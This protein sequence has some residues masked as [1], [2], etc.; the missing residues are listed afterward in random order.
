MKIITFVLV[1]G[2]AASSYG[3]DVL[4]QPLKSEEGQSFARG[5]SWGTLG[6]GVA[7][8]T[9]EAWKQDDKKK[10]FTKEGLTFGVVGATTLLIKHFYPEARPCAPSNCGSENP[11]ASEWS[12]HAANACAAITIK[13]GKVM[14]ITGAA[15]AFLTAEG[16]IW[17]NRHWVHNVLFG[18]AGGLTT[19]YLVGKI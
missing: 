1:L 15:L 12:G 19:S 14:W 11:Q 9:W 18:C 2:L 17:G 10:S 3:Q 6:A 7:L 5:M 13:S 8:K 16:R 4:T